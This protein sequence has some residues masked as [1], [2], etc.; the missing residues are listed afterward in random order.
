MMFRLGNVG[1]IFLLRKAVLEV[2]V[3]DS[4]VCL[5]DVILKEVQ[6]SSVL[7]VYCVAGWL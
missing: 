5:C 1:L 6:S 4:I 2:I 3:K 7:F